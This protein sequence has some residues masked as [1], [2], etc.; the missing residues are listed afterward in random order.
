MEQTPQPQSRKQIL[1]WVGL[2]LAFGL[3]L[4]T[5]A[6]AAA[7]GLETAYQNRIYPGVSVGGLRLDGMTREA[8]R[9][10]LTAKIDR[11]L[12][13]G[14]RFRF[15]EADFTLPRTT[16]SLE[17][18]DVSQDLVRY[19]VD[20]AIST[21]YQ[22]GRGRGITS[23]S[24][25]RLGLLIR[26]TDLPLN[27]DFN[28]RLAERLLQSEVEE[29]SSLPS[30]ARLQITYVT[31]TGAILS[32]IIQEQTG[33]TG[34]TESALRT[35]EAQIKRLSF[36]PIII[37]SATIIPRVTS[38]T[39]RGL[40]D[41][42]PSFLSRAKRTFLYL[43]KRHEAATST[44]AGWVQASTTSD[45]A[46][47]NF[48]PELVAEGL[49]VFVKD[50]L[51]EP[52][53]GTLELDDE[54][55]FKTFEAPAEGIVVDGR[56]SA[57]DLLSAMQ[58]GAP[59]SSISLMHITPKITGEDAERLGITELLGVGRSNYS[60]SPTNRRKNIA[61]GRKKMNGILIAPGGEFSQLKVLGEIDAANGWYP[62]LVIKGNK[63]TPEYGGG[64]CQVGTTSFRAALSAGLPIVER[65]NHSYRVRYYEPAGT[66]ATIYDPAPDFRFKN[67]TPGHILITSQAQGD[68]LLFFI[69]GTKDGRQITQTTPRVYNIVAPPPKQVI[70]TTDLPPG[71]VKCT[72]SAHAGATASFDYTVVYPDGTEKKE[73]FVSQYRP[74]G[75]VC[76][77]GATPEE[78]ALAAQPVIDQT[79]VNNPN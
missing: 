55:N 45:G 42:V 5:G 17:D 32:E 22:T 2:G 71:Q 23:D 19:D 57:M 63:T 66:D 29:R 78:V 20:A 43:G 9:V 62:E 6:A 73:T 68:N 48:D 56:K 12:E 24:L 67:D 18:P 46:A 26:R 30:N 37:Q 52:K 77:Q 3:I 8:A 69:W 34:D 13:P 27:A 16:L 14:F 76:L 40:K 50:Y 65:R 61:L 74:W 33:L 75:A 15:G 70:L 31:S 54:L 51:V 49:S 41:Q 60:G 53:D 64:L 36:Q 58:R 47:L 10:A 21:A 4:V 28:R 11:V 35:L 72:E 25:T 1:A 59:T 79:G 39:L 44:L 38:A 7:Y